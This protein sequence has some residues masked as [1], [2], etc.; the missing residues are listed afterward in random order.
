MKDSPK[1]RKGESQL[2]EWTARLNRFAEA[3][4]PEERQAVLENALQINP[5]G[6]IR[7]MLEA[8]GYSA[9]GRGRKAKGDEAAKSAKPARERLEAAL[10][11]LFGDERSP[12]RSLYP[13]LAGSA[14]LSVRDAARIVASMISTWPETIT[15]LSGAKTREERKRRVLA[16][17][18]GFVRELFAELS[19]GQSRKWTFEH[20]ERRV[21]KLIDEERVGVSHFIK[22]AGEQEGGLIVAGARDILVGPTPIDIIKDFSKLTTD[23]IADKNKGILI[24][25]FDASIFESDDYQINLLHNIGLLSSAVTAFALFDRNASDAQAIKMLTVQWERWRK[26]A[27]RCCVVMR[28]PPLIDPVSG[29]LF[30]HQSFD[31]FVAGW[32]PKRE[33]ARLGEFRGLMS[34]DSE[35]VLPRTYPSEF[36]ERDDW[37]GKDLYW[38]VLIRPSP[39]SPEKLAVEYFFPPVQWFNKAQPE[40]IDGTDRSR[41]GRGRRPAET[42]PLEE[43]SFYVVRRNSPGLTF[44][45]AQRAI[46]RAARGRLNLDTGE[47]HSENLLAAAALRQLGYEVLPISVAITLLPRSLYFAAAEPQDSAKSA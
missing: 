27:S 44:D 8:W 10:K 26:F 7:S 28:R 43:D 19:A 36:G 32:R 23:F 46:Y 25:V 3:R 5:G 30:A 9:S 47:R 12:V 45:S 38:D 41:N 42:L 16:L 11:D 15:G 17:D 18:E 13:K 31:D 29:E 39:E 24:F 14:E 35:H 37:T 6:T 33:F 1:R 4:T 21:F 34:F 20:M 2:K 40:G 22:D